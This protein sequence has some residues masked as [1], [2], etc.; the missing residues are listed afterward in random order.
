MDA[1]NRARPWQIVLAI[2]PA[3]ALTIATPLANHVEP[4]VL[5]LPFLLTYI[6]FWICVT[7]A[8]L[9]A[10]YRLEPPA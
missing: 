10:I 9:Y 3:I 1:P 2:I 8:F 6:V 7:P 4:R 5:G